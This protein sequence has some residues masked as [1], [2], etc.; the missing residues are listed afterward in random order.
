[1]KENIVTDMHMC[2]FELNTH[3]VTNIGET[4]C[5]TSVAIFENSPQGQSQFDQSNDSE[6]DEGKS[7][8]KL[9]HGFVH[10]EVL[11]RSK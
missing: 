2:R 7:A 4:V 9:K 5:E 8:G 6:H 11:T 1:M 3:Y 10:D